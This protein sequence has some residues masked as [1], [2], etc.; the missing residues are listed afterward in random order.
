VDRVLVGA[1]TGALTGSVLGAVT[2]AA[3]V[4]H[5][6]AAPAVA[7]ALGG[8]ALWSVPALGYAALLGHRDPPPP[9]VTFVVAVSLPLLQAEGAARAAS[10]ACVGRGPR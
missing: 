3:A 5:C 9:T 1:A 8:A 6:R 10:G 7:R 4:S 2:G